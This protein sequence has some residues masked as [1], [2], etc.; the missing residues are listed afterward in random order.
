V[1]GKTTQ[2]AVRIYVA[3]GGNWTE[4]FVKKVMHLHLDKKLTSFIK[5]LF[6]NW[7]TKELL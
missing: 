2:S 1:N 5:I 4:S 3:C 6:T 7:C